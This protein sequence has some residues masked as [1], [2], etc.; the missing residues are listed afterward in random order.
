MG[1]VAARPE[2][3]EL[4]PGGKDVDDVFASGKRI[5]DGSRQRHGGLEFREPVAAS[6]PAG[7]H[8]RVDHQRQAAV[9]LLLKLLDAGPAEAGPGS[10]VDLAVPITRPVLAGADILGRLADVGSESDAARLVPASQRDV[11]PGQREEF[12]KNEH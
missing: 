10:E 6:L 1:N 7:R 4:G 2:H 3:V 11:H 8:K 12:R 9:V 5:G